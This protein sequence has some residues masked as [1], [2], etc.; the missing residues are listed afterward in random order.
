MWGPR[1]V[2]SSMCLNHTSYQILSNIVNTSLAFYHDLWAS[3]LW[4]CPTITLIPI[5]KRLFYL[6]LWPTV[7]SIVISWE[8]KNF[9]ITQII[10]SLKCFHGDRWVDLFPTIRT[11][12]NVYELKRDIIQSMWGTRALMDC[13]SG[14]D[15]IP[16]G[17]PLVR[18]CRQNPTNVAWPKQAFRS[19]PR[20]YVLWAFP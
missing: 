12:K 11:R 3:S 19:F 10:I 14:G 15:M 17:G 5:E 13:P 6:S 7:S 9:Q 8:R 20:S 18:C 4:M 1:T 16:P 2:V